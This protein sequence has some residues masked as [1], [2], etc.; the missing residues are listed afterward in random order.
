MRGSGKQERAY[1][2]GATGTRCALSPR[3]IGGK[4][5]PRL[6]SNLKGGWAFEADDLLKE[7]K[8]RFQQGPRVMTLNFEAGYMHA[9]LPTRAESRFSLQTGPSP[10]MP[11]KFLPR[12]IEFSS[13]EQGER[14]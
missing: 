5:N 10:Y 7:S 11:P 12:M 1:R 8:R 2:L 4:K 6:L 13:N 14:G 3:R 9:V